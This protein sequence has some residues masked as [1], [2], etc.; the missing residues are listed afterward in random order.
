SDAEI[1]QALS[2]HP[3]IGGRADNSS[4]ARE[5]SAVASAD[6]AV[7]ENLRAGNE[8][9]EKKFGH[10]Y[11][12]CASGRSAQELLAILHERLRNDSLTERRILR[13]ELA[14]INRLRLEGLLD[15]Y[16]RGVR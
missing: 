12:V 16:S 3:R 5:Q 7:R 13:R 14:A 1:D 10:V 15:D 8:E 11:L 4:S 9:Y 6:D 2:G